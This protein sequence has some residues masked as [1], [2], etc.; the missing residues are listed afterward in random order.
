MTPALVAHDA[1]VGGSDQSSTLSLGLPQIATASCH[2]RGT[3]L[4]SLP[5]LFEKKPSPGAPPLFSAAE[6]REHERSRGT[7]S[8]GFGAFGGRAGDTDQNNTV[9]A[10]VP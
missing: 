5:L 4:L 2:R 3:F 9:W 1:C 10:G 7:A 6:K 8:S